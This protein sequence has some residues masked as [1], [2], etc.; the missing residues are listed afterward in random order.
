MFNELELLYDIDGKGV[1]IEMIIIKLENRY[2][3]MH[4]VIFKVLQNV[5]Y[6]NLI[7]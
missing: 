1:H 2:G 5:F 3:M 6:L 4:L 7:P